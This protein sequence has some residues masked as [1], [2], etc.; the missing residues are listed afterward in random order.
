MLKGMVSYVVTGVVTCVVMDVETCVVTFVVS[1]DMGGNM[2][3]TPVTRVAGSP[4]T[5]VLHPLL[6]RVTVTRNGNA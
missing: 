1:G 4:A 2:R 3:G 5:W 6:L